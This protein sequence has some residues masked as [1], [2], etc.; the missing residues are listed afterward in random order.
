MKDVP[1]HW[2]SVL[3]ALAHWV[4]YKKEYFYGHLLPEGA[5]V[6]ELTQL[7]AA[8]IN[9]GQ[10]LECE[11]MYKDFDSSINGQARA[12]IVIGSKPVRTEEEKKSHVKKMMSLDDL[13]EV[14]E[15]KRYEGNF[16]KT[17]EDF[18]KLAQ[19]KVNNPG[20]RLFQVVVG[21]RSLPVKL[22]TKAHSLHR[23]NLYDGNLGLDV[24]A[25]LAKKAYCSKKSV[26]SGVF[27]VLLEVV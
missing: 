2:H 8:N 25:R 4:A 18:E 9:E 14:V 12:D 5:I 21:Q 19:L 11:R 24:R 3:Q 22:F 20:L 26:T 13:A 23:K 7:I 17:Q 15:V 16:I 1:I 6:A 10:R 27:A